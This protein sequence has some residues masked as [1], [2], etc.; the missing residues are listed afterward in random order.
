MDGQTWLRTGDLGFMRDGEVFVTGR[1]KD[2]LIVRGQ[3]L[4]P[5][6]LEKTL[7]REVDVLRK[8]GWRCSPSTTRARRASAWRWRSAA[9]CRSAHPRGADQ[10]PAPGNRRRLPPGPGGGA[11]AQPRRAAQDL[12]RQAAAL[13]LPPAHERWQPG[14]L[15]ASRPSSAARKRRGQRPASAHRGIWRELLKVEAVA[16]DDHFLLLGG[17]SIAATQ[18]TARLGDELGIS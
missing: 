16:A 11:A 1:L 18:V 6:D 17:N 10:D 9:T 13:G 5:Q 2:M 4:Y 3:N 7:E 8:A 15:R 14:L 12:Q